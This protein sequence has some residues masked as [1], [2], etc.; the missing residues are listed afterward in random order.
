[1]RNITK[2]IERKNNRIS[3]EKGILE[4]LDHAFKWDIDVIKISATNTFEHNMAVCKICIQL[5]KQGRKFITEAI[6]KGGLR[7]DVFL[8]EESL[9]IEVLHS[10]TSKMFETKKKK[11][12]KKFVDI[13]YMFGYK[14]SDILKDGWEI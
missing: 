8:P 1:M 6:F 14:S 3:A 10:E 5:K 2:E 11:Y 13:G 9:I 4:M 12:M 7:A